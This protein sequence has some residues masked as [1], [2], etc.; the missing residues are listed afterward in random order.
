MVFLTSFPS[1]SLPWATLV[2]AAAEEVLPAG[3]PEFADPSNVRNR[4]QDKSML[5]I[6]LER[7]ATVEINGESEHDGRMLIQ[8]PFEKLNHQ[9]M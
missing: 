9:E 1:K 7:L 8:K 6:R 2:S 5:L 4:L 3:C